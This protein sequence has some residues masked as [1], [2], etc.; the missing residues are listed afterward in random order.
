[1]AQ[2]D[3]RIVRIQ[4]DIKNLQTFSGEGVNGKDGIASAAGPF[5]KTLIPVANLV[6]D[7][8]YATRLEFTAAQATTQGSSTMVYHVAQGRWSAG[9]WLAV[10]TVAQLEQSSGS[11]SP[12]GG[13]AVNMAGIV[14]LR[15]EF[16]SHKSSNL[17][18][19]WM[20]TIQ[21]IDSSAPLL[22]E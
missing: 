22:T 14:P 15:L 9:G 5:F 7:K 6:V 3:A 13:I 12:G 19:T 17:Y 4:S 1:M 8:V 21:S 20:A 16:T 2:Q 18:F 11:Y 10:A